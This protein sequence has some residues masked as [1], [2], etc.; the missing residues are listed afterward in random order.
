MTIQSVKLNNTRINLRLVVSS[1]INLAR[2]KDEKK[3][4]L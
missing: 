4:L 1:V 3:R 2:R